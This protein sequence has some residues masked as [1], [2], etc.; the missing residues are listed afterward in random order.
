MPKSYTYNIQ[1][2]R[3]NTVIYGK[4]SIKYNAPLLWNSLP[5]E[6][7]TS[8]TLTG[9]KQNVTLWYGIEFQCGFCVPC[10]MNYQC[11]CTV[12]FICMYLTCNY[13]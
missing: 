5:D 8:P 11:V 6:M 12:I 9:F 10:K 7:K 1:L 4:L 3:C 2:P 13:I